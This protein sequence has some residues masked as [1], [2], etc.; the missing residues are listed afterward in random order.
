M[1]EDEISNIVIGC[2][3]LFIKLWGLDCWKVLI[4]NVCF[5]SWFNPVYM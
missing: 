4:K 5:I 1:S 3:F 2:G